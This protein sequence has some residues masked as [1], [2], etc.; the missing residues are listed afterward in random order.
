MRTRLQTPMARDIPGVRTGLA[1]A[2]VLWVVVVM[3]AIVAIVGQTSRLDW[4]V[5]TGAVDELRCKWACRAGTE[6][7]IALLNEDLKDTDCLLDLWSDDDA[8]YNNVQLERCTYSVRVTDEA[9]KLNVNTATKQQLMALPYMEENIADAIL[10]WRDRDK[11]LRVNGAEAGYYENLPFPYT[12]RD[13]PFRTIRELLRV[14]DVTEALLYGED[15]NLNGRLDP[16]EMDGDLSPP[17]DN[18]D[19]YLDRGWI[20]YLTCYSY[21]R[22]VD[23]EGNPRI[24]INQADERQ[25]ETGLGIQ[26][27]QARWIVQNRGRGYR[28]IADLISS[29]SPQQ[30]AGGPETTRQQGP[31]GRQDQGNRQNQ[32]NQ[33]NRESAEPIDLQTFAQ[34]ADR[35]TISGEDRAPGKININTAPWEVLVVLF[36]GG[37]QAEQIAYAIIAER[38]GLL[39]GFQSIADLVNVQSVGLAAFRRV[40]DQITVRSDVFTVRCVAT[41]DISGAQL[42]TE[43]VVDRSQTP[44]RI[45]YWYQGANY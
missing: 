26:S 42:Q 39:Y 45:L 24:N 9:G 2:M 1:L 36:G 20:A 30:R 5:A 14:K 16:G 13:N 40:A 4:K 17:A 35:I 43:C 37:E 11:N 21:E 10:D 32:G 28:S 8:D 41:A 22:N 18:G 15:A 38:S 19:D 23:A 29:N 3:L 27:S 25:L 12:I 31:E 34:I 6:T 44:C 7:A 33:R